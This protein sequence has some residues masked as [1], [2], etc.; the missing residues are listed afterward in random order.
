MN[1]SLSL[2]SFSE[3]LNRIKN[4]E[5]EY[6]IRIKWLENAD[7]VN[8]ILIMSKIEHIIYSHSC[9][10]GYPK[11]LWR[12]INNKEGGQT[13]SYARIESDDILSDD[14][15]DMK[16]WKIANNIKEYDKMISAMKI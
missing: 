3:A 12:Y 10:S 8:R 2:L 13:G 6:M 5:T 15:L 9:V 4:K 16:E 14:W 11:M 7:F 1:D